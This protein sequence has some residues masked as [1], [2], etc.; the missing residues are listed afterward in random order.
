[1]ASSPQETIIVYHYSLSRG[2]LFCKIVDEMYCIRTIKRW[3]CRSQLSSISIQSNYSHVKS[4][5]FVRRRNLETWCC[6]EWHEWSPVHPLVIDTEMAI[7]QNWA[8][9]NF[10]CRISCSEILQTNRFSLKLWIIQN[11]D[12]KLANLTRKGK[13]FQQWELYTVLVIGGRHQVNLHFI[14]FYFVNL[15]RQFLNQMLF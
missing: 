13:C 9:T 12:W 10:S 11:R 6:G 3:H 4:H 15:F 5:L 1:M 14:H 7:A 8:W 2:L